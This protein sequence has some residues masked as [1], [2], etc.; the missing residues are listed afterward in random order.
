[1]KYDFGISVGGKTASSTAIETRHD[2]SDLRVLPAKG[3]F[4]PSFRY[5]PSY[6][7]DLRKTF[8]RIRLQLLD[9]RRTGLT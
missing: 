2:R 5:T 1:M 6:A 4:D 3:I 8:E 9:S 7:T